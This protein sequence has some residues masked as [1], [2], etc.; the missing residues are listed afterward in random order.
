VSRH[1]SRRSTH[2]GSAEAALEA[3]E[4]VSELDEWVHR[5]DF[6]CHLV[7]WAFVSADSLN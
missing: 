1:R 3:I 6:G 7:T 5:C 4:T 2:A